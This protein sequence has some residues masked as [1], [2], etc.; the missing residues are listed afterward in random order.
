MEYSTLLNLQNLAFRLLSTLQI[1]LIIPLLRLNTGHTNLLDDIL[2]RLP[3]LTPNNLDNF[4]SD[5]F[6]PLF[7]AIITNK[8][9]DKIWRQVYCTVTETTPPP[10]PTASHF[11]QTPRSINTSNFANSSEYRKHIDMDELGAI[12]VDLPDFYNIFIGRVAAS[13]AI[14]KKYIK[15][16]EPLFRNSWRGEKL[17]M[18]AEEYHP[19]RILTPRRRLLRWSHV[20]VP[21]E[22]KSNPS[23]DIASNAWLDLRRYAREEFNRLGAIA[24]KQFDINTEGLQFVSTMSEEELGFD[25][26]F[27]K[28]NNKRRNSLPERLIINKQYPKCDEEGD[29]LREAT[30]K[31]VVNT[32]QVRGTD[33]DI[34]SNVRRGIDN[35]RPEHLTPPTRTVTAST[36]RKGYTG[37]KWSSSQTDAALPSNKRSCTTQASN[38]SINNLI[39]NKDDNNPSW[40]S[41]LIDLDLAV[42]KEREG[43]SGAKGMTGTRAF[44]AI[45]VLLREQHSFMH[46]LESFFWVLFWIYVHYNGPN[47][48]DSMVVDEFEQWNYTSPV[49]LAKLKK[50]T[51]DDE[52]D[53]IESAE[54]N[55]TP[56]YRPLIPWVNKLRREVFPNGGRW[57]KEDEGLYDRMRGILEKAREDP[58]VLRRD[59]STN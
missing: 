18:F 3:A 33:D 13:Q 59:S 40:P 50:A 48:S 52:G 57:E 16:N 39:I 17:A 51:V 30:D 55:F 47:D 37:K 8:P 27:I 34:R 1:L 31:G 45:G 56:Y 11:L 32:V 49:T 25:P 29:L 19:N 7:N 42:R 24:S 15:S 41:F 4:D 38:I 12:Y 35:Y 2:R 6:E 53:F 58:K 46:D 10:R 14:F 43:A 21:G 54:E 5:Q 28:E 9:D 26:S 44:M 20:L 36:S 22:L 23:A